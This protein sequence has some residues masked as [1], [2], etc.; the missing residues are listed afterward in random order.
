MVR[1]RD[2]NGSM[3]SCRIVIEKSKSAYVPNARDRW[4]GITESGT[5]IQNLEIV[6]EGRG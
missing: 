6:M 3:L 1:R 5:S 2:T 4:R